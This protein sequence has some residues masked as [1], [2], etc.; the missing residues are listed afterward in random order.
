MC[1]TITV[2][3]GETLSRLSLMYSISPSRL[4]VLNNLG[5]RDVHP[6][7]VLKLE[8]PLEY[9]LSRHHLV[10]MLISSLDFFREDNTIHDDDSGLKNHQIDEFSILKSAISGSIVLTDDLLIF[11]QIQTGSAIN[12]ERFSF[13]INLIAISNTNLVPFYKHLPKSENNQQRSK[14]KNEGNSNPKKGE[15]SQQ[16][17]S[18]FKRL[19]SSK[20]EKTDNDTNNNNQE[21]D[22]S[23]CELNNENNKSNGTQPKACSIQVNFKPEIN[24]NGKET[25]LTHY[26]DEPSVLEVCFYDDPLNKNHGIKS[27]SLFASRAEL[28]SLDFLIN[29]FSRQRRIEIGHKLTHTIELPKSDQKNDSTLNAKA[30]NSSSTP[31]PQ[32]QFSSS[33]NKTS[34]FNIIHDEHLSNFGNNDDDD[35]THANENKFYIDESPSFGCAI[36]TTVSLI[37]ENHDLPKKLNSTDKYRKVGSLVPKSNLSLSPIFSPQ[38]VTK[39]TLKT[40]APISCSSLKLSNAIIPDS[41]SPF[42]TDNFSY[43]Q[44]PTSLTNLTSMILDCVNITMIR[45]HFPHRIMG[46]AWHLAF[47]LS[48][49]GC[50][51]HTL[52]D[53]TRE[54]RPCVLCILTTKGE[55]IGAFLGNGIHEGKCKSNGGSSFIFSFNMPTKKTNKSKIS[56]NSNDNCDSDSNTNNNSD[57]NSNNN[58]DDHKSDSNVKNGSDNNK[59]QPSYFHRRNANVYRWSMLNDK[60]IIISTSDLMIGS[61]S[62]NEGRDKVKDRSRLFSN[63]RSDIGGYGA[64][65]WIDQ[66]MNKGISENCP[67]F[68]SPPL[69]E[70]GQFSVSDIEVWNIF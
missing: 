11:N 28:N 70:G 4:R 2:S 43:S 21:L 9:L 47:R 59:H 39:S 44:Y 13:Y 46:S 18:F 17:E 42:F 60:F 26:E 58:D 45:S 22:G 68:N 35:F 55:S 16:K 54:G 1:A 40:L 25:F 67:T 56:N 23:R 57:E 48:R 10:V 12:K 36:Q 64:A 49:D 15:E 37:P 20:N 65:I 7:D 50:S 62:I 63:Y 41:T 61:T 32:V 53:R 5:I 33:H 27:I 52:L 6:G 19:F 69:V 24:F 66:K 38:T 14:L 30:T 34:L 29:F 31:L 51:Y 3:E 8:S